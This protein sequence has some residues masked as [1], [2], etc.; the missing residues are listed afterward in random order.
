MNK[1]KFWLD[2]L[3]NGRWLILSTLKATGMS[4][5]FKKK[6][7]KIR[8]E[9]LNYI[10]QVWIR[11]VHRAGTNFRNP[12]RPCRPCRPC[13]PMPPGSGGIGSFAALVILRPLLPSLTSNPAIEEMR[14]RECC[15]TSTFTGS[16]IPDFD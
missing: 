6:T 12:C 11:C 4:N 16:I 13:L 5:F 1:K 3:K 2:F 14:S 7:L 15:S 10:I 8:S 9:G